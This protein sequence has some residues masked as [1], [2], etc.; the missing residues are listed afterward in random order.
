MGVWIP[1]P[2]LLADE[3]I[4]WSKVANRK[5]GG[6]AVGGRLV[7]TSSR[8]LFIPN[9]IDA[10]TGGK[11]WECPVA[12]ITRIEAMPRDSDIYAGGLRNRLVIRGDK[13]FEVF[14]VNKLA[15]VLTE[16]QSILN[17]A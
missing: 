13:V 9:R 14:V 5:Q 7:V 1:A 3:Q 17:L 10:L 8:A 15:G 2:K 11:N 16:L 4:R 6:R 12:R